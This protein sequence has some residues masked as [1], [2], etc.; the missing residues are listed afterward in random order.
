MAKYTVTHSCGH[1]EVVDLWGKGK[2]RKSRLEWLATVPCMECKRAA[3]LADT[4]E[5]EQ[6]LGLNPNMKGTERQVAWARSLRA[7]RME[8]LIALAKEGGFIAPTPKDA[9]NA[10]V[11]FANRQDAS[12]WIDGRFSNCEN[13]IYENNDEI[14]KDFEQWIKN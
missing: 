10:L 6:R 14:M 12:V 4:V 1:E 5:T 8:Q 9:I 2:D 13:F 11:K 7:D 3:E